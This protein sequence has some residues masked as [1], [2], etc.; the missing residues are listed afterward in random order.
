MR[1]LESDQYMEKLWNM[2]KKQ[3]FENKII[4][5]TYGYIQK[6]QKKMSQ[7]RRGAAS[8]K[9]LIEKP[10]DKQKRYFKQMEI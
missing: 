5:K 2:M 9:R 1:N 10:V 8:Y 7:T 3:N 4:P 6:L